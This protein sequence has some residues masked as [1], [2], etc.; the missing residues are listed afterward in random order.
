MRRVGGWARAGLMAGVALFVAVG[1][2]CAKKPQ[3]QN[4]NMIAGRADSSVQSGTPRDFAVNVGDRV[5]FLTDSAALT[6]DARVVLNGQIQW[7]RAYP[8]YRITIEGHSDERG[9]REYNL[10]LAARRAAA[11]KGY[12]EGQGIDTRRMKTTSFGKER[13]VALCDDSVCWSQNRRAVSVVT[14]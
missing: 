7:L 8:N 4:P 1:A 5:H 11:V 2:G 12:L 13:P 9:T 3:T 10:A 6:S 14:F